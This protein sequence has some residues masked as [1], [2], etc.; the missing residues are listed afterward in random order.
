MAKYAINIEGAEALHI[1]SDKLSGSASDI[2][3][4]SLTM[5]SEIKALGKELGIY[6]H[7]ITYLV[8]NIKKTMIRNADSIRFLADKSK[9]N[10]INLE[11][12][13]KGSGFLI[14]YHGISKQHSSGVTDRQKMVI[15]N[16]TTTS[17]SGINKYLDSIDVDRMSPALKMSICDQI[18]VLT[19]CIDKH[20]LPESG[21]LYRGINSREIFGDDIST[22]TPDNIIQ[23]YQGTM[24]HSN[25]FLSTSCKEDKAKEYGEQKNGAVIQFKLPKGTKGLFLG[26]L[27][28]FSMEEAEVLLQRG[29]S[30]RFDSITYDG[31]MYN[32][33]ATITG[34][35]Y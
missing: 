11:T 14:S 29:T 16:Y 25:R 28:S 26:D 17:H 7:Y 23:K 22:M 5:E 13:L 1:L 9:E 30:Y 33:V 10:A 19:E 27:P 6:N 4:V 20:E 15:S 35:D 32:I 24:K 31:Y 2:L 34:C 21:V 12:M 18:N 3:N 8:A